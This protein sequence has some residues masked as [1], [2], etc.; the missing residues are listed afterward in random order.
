MVGLIGSAVVSVALAVFVPDGFHTGI[1]S[2]LSTWFWLVVSAA[3]LAVS[4]KWKK[5]HPVVII[6]ISAVI[7]IG[8]GFLGL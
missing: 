5:L 2:D 4:L 6:C 7:G 8:A 1:F 3:L